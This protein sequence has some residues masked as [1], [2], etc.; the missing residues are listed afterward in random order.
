MG[1][2]LLGLANNHSES[3]FVILKMTQKLDVAVLESVLVAHLPAQA[4]QWRQMS[5][6]I[7]EAKTHGRWSL[8]EFRVHKTR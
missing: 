4:N 5:G 3:A 7:G 2:C 1:V 8:H 6:T